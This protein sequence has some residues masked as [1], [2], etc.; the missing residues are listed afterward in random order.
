[1]V[2]Y[3][4]IKN[5]FKLWFL[6]VFK[7]AQLRCFIAIEIPGVIRAALA[8]LQTEL[9]ECNAD[10]RWV[11]P[12]NIHLTLRFLGDVDEH[13]VDSIVSALADVSGRHEQFRL[14]VKGLGLF[15]NT[16]S[17]RVLWSDVIDEGPLA[18]LQEEIEAAMAGIGFVPE[19]RR[20]SAHLT[21]GRFKSAS[22]KD[23]INRGI[24]ARGNEAPGNMDVISVVLMQSDLTPRGAK[25]SKISEAF[26]GRTAEHNE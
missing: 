15:P 7:G 11:K 6:P 25:Y 26:L 20:F 10:I 14:Q 2:C 5:L 17:P 18:R 8:E 12:D 9:R 4:N 23:C 3:L 13:R 16:R 22:G 21:L 1:V 19:K 24:E